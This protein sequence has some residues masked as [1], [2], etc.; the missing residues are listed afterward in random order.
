MRNGAGR[1]MPTRTLCSRFTERVRSKIRAFRYR[2]RS[3]SSRMGLGGTKE[4]RRRPRARSLAIHAASM[5]SVFRPVTCLMW[6][7]VDE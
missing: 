3:R 7:G 2:V 1:S 6:G 4:G 5:V